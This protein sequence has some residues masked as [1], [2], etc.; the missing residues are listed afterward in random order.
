MPSRR[1][2]CGTVSFRTSPSSARA[3]LCPG[4]S[5]RSASA[6]AFPA[7]P[8]DPANYGLSSPWEPLRAAGEEGQAPALALL[9]EL[10][11]WDE[12][13]GT[14]TPTLPSASLCGWDADAAWKEGSAEQGTHPSSLIRGCRAGPSRTRA[15]GA[16]FSWWWRPLLSAGHTLGGDFHSG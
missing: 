8:S 11:Q 14:Q 15:P 3:A 5:G 7:P 12:I 9:P 4:N 13:E 2:L 16:V 1:S 10:L 6:L